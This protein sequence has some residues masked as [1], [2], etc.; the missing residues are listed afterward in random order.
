MLTNTL[1]YKQKVWSSCDVFLE[2]LTE[3]KV[4]IKGKDLLELGCGT[5]LLGIACI[6][7]GMS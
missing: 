6:K 7:L 5:G 2:L 3:N 1:Y 4:D